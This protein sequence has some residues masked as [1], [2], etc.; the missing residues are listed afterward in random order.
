MGITMADRDQA[1]RD[2]SASRLRKAEQSGQFA[3]SRE[4]SVAVIWLAGIAMLLTLGTTLW[5]EISQLGKRNWSTVDTS[6]A[7]QV[8]LNQNLHA[9]ETVFW[10]GMLPILAGVAAV[11]GLVW[12]T[13]SGFRFFPQLA[14]PDVSRISPARNLKRLVEPESRIA[15]LAGLTKFISLILIASWILYGE[16]EAFMT[17]GQG[18]LESQSHEMMQWVA[19][20][21]QRLCLAAIAV[22]MLDYGIRWRLNRQALM[23][24]EQ[25]VRDEHRAMEPAPEVTARRRLLRRR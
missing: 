5:H 15:I 3:R 17:L 25:E 1:T 2:P 22:G 23:M 24:S 18:S 7:P 9:S 14:I 16:R 12:W 11:A 13:Q 10:N 19:S 20:V 21:V 6:L 4:L 8:W